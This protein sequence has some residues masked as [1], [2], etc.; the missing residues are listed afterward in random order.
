MRGMKRTMPLA[1]DSPDPVELAARLSLT[2]NSGPIFGRAAGE[3]LVTNLDFRRDADGAITLD[4]SLTDEFVRLPPQHPQPYS[5]ADWSA[6]E[7][8]LPLAD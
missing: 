4:I 6:I 8:A 1:A 5:L 3:L 2:R 7:P